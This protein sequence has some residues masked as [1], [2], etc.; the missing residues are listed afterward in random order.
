MAHSTCLVA[1]VSSVGGHRKN[2]GS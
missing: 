1:I 2:I